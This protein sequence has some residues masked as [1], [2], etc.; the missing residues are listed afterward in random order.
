MGAKPIGAAVID[1]SDL[2]LI[3]EQVKTTC[4]IREQFV[5]SAAFKSDTS[6][7]TTSLPS[8]VNAHLNASKFPDQLDGALSESS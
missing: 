4:D 5:I 6:V 3:F 7:T 8:S 2:K 1:R